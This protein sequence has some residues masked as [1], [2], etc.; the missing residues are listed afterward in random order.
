MKELIIEEVQ[1]KDRQTKIF[2]LS[3]MLGIEGSTGIQ[4]L[5]EA[6]FSEGVRNTIFE[7]SGLEF[8]SSAGVGAFISVT[9]ELRVAG[10]EIVFALMPKQILRVF[11][12]LD[13]TDYFKVCDTVEEA[14]DHLSRVND[15]TALERGQPEEPVLDGD[16][17]LPAPKLEK[18]LRSFSAEILTIKPENRPLSTVLMKVARSFDIPWLVL[19]MPNQNGT[20]TLSAAGGKQAGLGQGYR[21]TA[22]SS[23]LKQLRS[24][25]S[26]FINFHHW[27]KKL[28]PSR[29]LEM[30][31]LAGTQGIFRLRDEK[32]LHSFVCFGPEPI[33]EDGAEADLLALLGY[34]LNWFVIYHSSRQEL[35]TE[36]DAVAQQLQ[37]STRELAS[38]GNKLTRKMIELRTIF[39]ASRN[40]TQNLATHKLI[41]NLLMTLIGQ[42]AAESAAVFL[43][44]K[45]RLNLYQIKGVN[46]GEG[47][48]F[49]APVTPEFT[50]RLRSAR[51]PL[52]L[53][54]LAVADKSRVS[55]KLAD[56]GLHVVTGLTTSHDFLGLIALGRKLGE[57]T[58]NNEDLQILWLLSRQVAVSLENAKFFE[59]LDHQES[60]R[61]RRLISAIDARDPYTRG[62]SERVSRHVA[63]L[64]QEIKMNREELQQV[65]YGAVLHDVGMIATLADATIQDTVKLSKEQKRQVNSHPDVGANLLE[66]MGFDGRCVKT[67]RQHHERW[68]GEGYPKALSGEGIY[69]GARLVSI[70]DAYDTLTSGRR[71]RKPIPRD[72][73][74]S[75]LS[76][77][78]GRRYDSTLVEKF[79]AMM[80]RS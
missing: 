52:P 35:T 31:K 71:Y 59:Q 74:L 80:M 65:V 58:Y 73:A 20:F 30:L 16:V 42:L 25:E 13:L 17:K 48:S 27:I 34:L 62:H 21:F 15:S 29:E 53:I 57:N 22:K 69:L 33:A 23:F 36:L 44:E 10:G 39:S 14:L 3:G 37:T 67:V 72:D 66:V 60:E 6:C 64:A 79:I 18:A 26:D 77:E 75:E 55:E 49:S 32:G 47:V 70:A 40:L 46:L 38:S 61:I 41:G 50:E 2:R 5:F 8:I 51:E 63:L 56:L 11:D 24:A 7:L 4:R 19:F 68:D 45:G 1:H 12:S 28:P 9:R 43:M 78:S 54:A 76:R